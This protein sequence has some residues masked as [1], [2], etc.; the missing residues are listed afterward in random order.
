MAMIEISNKVFSA[1]QA[2]QYLGF[3]YWLL[4]DLVRQGKIKHYRGG[5]RL[6]F[7]QQSLDE[8]IIEQ[9]QISTKTEK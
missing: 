7:R 9:E 5:N 3:S 6:L 8:W 2:A 4:L 1:K